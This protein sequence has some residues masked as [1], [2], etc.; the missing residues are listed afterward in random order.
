MILGATYPGVYI[1]DI[2]PSYK[3]HGS[4]VS[5]RPFEADVPARIELELIEIQSRWVIQIGPRVYGGAG[6]ARSSARSSS[7][8]H[9]LSR[10]MKETAGRTTTSALGVVGG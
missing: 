7:S 4:V 10:T 3:H 8:I 5:G 1:N 2:Y 6:T 9:R